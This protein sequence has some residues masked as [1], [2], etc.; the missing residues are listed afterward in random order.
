MKANSVDELDN[1]ISVINMSY[2]VLRD[3]LLVIGH[4]RKEWVDAAERLG[5]RVGFVKVE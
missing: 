5:L 1:C 4:N 2:P 3:M